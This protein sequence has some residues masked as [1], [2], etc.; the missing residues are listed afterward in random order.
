VR[1]RGPWDSPRIVP[2]FEKAID[3]NLREER[4]KAEDRLEREVQERLNITPEEG[5][6]LEDAAKDKLEERA[7]RELRKLFE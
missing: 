4:K 2:D 5:Q 7:K 3:M 1:I 6:S